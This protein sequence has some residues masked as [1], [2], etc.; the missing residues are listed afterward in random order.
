MGEGKASGGGGLGAALG[1][2]KG[3]PGGWGVL[4][5]K[6]SFWA[7]AGGCRNH[8]EG[9]KPQILAPGG[10]EGGLDGAGAPAWGLV[11]AHVSPAS[12]E[13]FFGKQMGPEQGLAAGLKPG[14]THS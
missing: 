9:V 3:C 11:L 4:G 14:I 10:C 2:N 7:S 1:S 6:R 8:L 5:Q 12:A 13:A